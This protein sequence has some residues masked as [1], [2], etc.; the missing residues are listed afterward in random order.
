MGR[1][2]PNKKRACKEIDVGNHLAEGINCA[3][4]ELL[5]KCRSCM[6]CRER[7]AGVLMAWGRLSEGVHGSEQ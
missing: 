5:E 4:A 2:Y 7:R 1:S 3:K 6:H